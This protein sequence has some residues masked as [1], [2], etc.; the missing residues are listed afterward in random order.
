[1]KILLAV[2][3]SKT[4][5][6]AVRHLVAHADWFREPPQIELVTVHGEISVPR[7]P[8]MGGIGKAQMEKYYEEEGAKRLTEAKRLLDQAKAR[9]ETRVLVGPAAETIVKH[10]QKSGADL[11]VVGAPQAIIGSVCTKVMHLS[12]VPVLLVK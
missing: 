10:A 9:Y 12:E 6:D 7:F 5:L 1:M 8:G 2:D 11:I 4:S 3:G